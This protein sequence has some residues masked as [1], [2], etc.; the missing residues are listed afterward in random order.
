ML[1]IFKLLITVNIS[2]LGWGWDEDTQ[3]SQK[4]RWGSISHPH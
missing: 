3:T 2:L 4:R 1:N